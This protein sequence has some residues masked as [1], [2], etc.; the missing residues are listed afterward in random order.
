MHFGFESI[1]IFALTFKDA[2]VVY[3]CL[4]HILLHA[5]VYFSPIL[6]NTDLVFF[7]SQKKP[8]QFFSVSF[9]GNVLLTL[10]AFSSTPPSII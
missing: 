8:K 9:F 5:N 1:I 6:H 3:Q 10:K 4:Y 7:F 2:G